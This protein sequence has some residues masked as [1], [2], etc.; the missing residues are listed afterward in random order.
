MKKQESLGWKKSVTV[1]GVSISVIHPT[2]HWDHGQLEC[3]IKQSGSRNAG[4]SL[5]T[6]GDPGHVSMWV[7]EFPWT[8]AVSSWWSPNRV[9]NLF[10]W[11]TAKGWV[12]T[13]N[14]VFLK[15]SNDNTDH[16]LWMWEM[17]PVHSLPCSY[18]MKKGLLKVSKELFKAG[19]WQDVVVGQSGD[20]FLSSRDSHLKG[21]ILLCC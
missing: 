7:Q 5:E 17:D 11:L 21:L 6:R 14:K 12:E 9:W 1:M 19:L 8:Q 4:N 3:K 20:T 2:K 10:W 13:Q 18:W 16:S 15:T